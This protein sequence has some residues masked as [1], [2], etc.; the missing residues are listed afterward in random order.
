MNYFAVPA[1][2]VNGSVRCSIQVV[3]ENEKVLKS[4]Y[5]SC[6]DQ[7]GKME[8]Y[9]RALEYMDTLPR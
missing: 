8:A 4:F 6:G 7:A 9:T 3:D 2:K 1:K 5:Y